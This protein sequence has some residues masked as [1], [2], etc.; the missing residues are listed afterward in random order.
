MRVVCTVSRR[1]SSRT[2][3]ALA[4]GTCSQ[5]LSARTQTHIP[6]MRTLLITTLEVRETTHTHILACIT[7]K[8]TYNSSMNRQPAAQ[9]A[10]TPRPHAHAA[11]Y[12]TRGKKEYRL[13]C[14]CVC[15]CV[16]SVCVYACEWNMEIF[17]ACL[18]WWLIQLQVCTMCAARL[19]T[20]PLT[21]TYSLCFSSSLWIIFHTSPMSKICH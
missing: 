20:S 19:L 12:D 4:T 2:A 11:D 18:R 16:F 15:D 21:H 14:M 9:R 3:Y 7:S 5:K 17:C 1:R 8:S 13:V 10:H 6:M